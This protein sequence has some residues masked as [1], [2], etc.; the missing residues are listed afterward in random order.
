[1][2]KHMVSGAASWSFQRNKKPVGSAEKVTVTARALLQRINRK[3]APDLEK[4]MACKQSSRSYNDLGDYYALDQNRN[5]IIAQHIDLEA[6]GRE[7]GVL[8]D[9]EKLG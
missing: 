5:A 9:W 6:W 1:M 7:M 3:L 4:V 8:K 2:P